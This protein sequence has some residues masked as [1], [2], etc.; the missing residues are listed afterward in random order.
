[1]CVL[2]NHISQITD[3]VTPTKSQSFVYDELSRLIEADGGYGALN[4]Q[5]DAVGNRLSQSKTVGSQNLVETYS[6]ATGSHR[7]QQITEQAGSTT[8]TRTL[9]YDAN[10]NL[11]QD[12][13]LDGQQFILNYN[14]S[15]RLS[16]VDK[17]SVPLASYLHNA[18]GQRVAKVAT[19]PAQDEHYFYDEAGQLLAVA[20]RADGSMT[21]YVYLDQH[22]IA[23]IKEPVTQWVTSTHC[24]SDNDNDGMSDP[25]EL[26]FFGNLER[27]GSGDFD[28]DGFTDLE[29]YDR[30]T[31]PNLLT[32]DTDSLPDAWELQYFGSLGHTP[33]QDSDNDGYSNAQEYA[34]GTDPSDPRSGASATADVDGDGMLDRWE[35]LYF[36][37]L[38]RNGTSDFDGDYVSDRLE[39]SAGTNPTDATSVNEQQRRN[40]LVPIMNTYFSI[41]W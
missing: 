24:W 23:M 22:R 12:Q 26:S 38:T 37:N 35:M 33:E 34:D 14:G 7:L 16:E 10:G 39:F 31:Q 25:W 13:R 20:H 15:N 2:I 4:Y 40:A 11:I 21:H 6:Y 1:V 41:S 28:G 5:Y 36:G 29:E 30:D 18:L 8:R 19:D 32:L 17:S 9:Q 3:A 27:D